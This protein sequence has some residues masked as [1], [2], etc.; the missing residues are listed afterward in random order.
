MD[1]NYIFMYRFIIILIFI[2]SFFCWVSATPKIS[3][4]EF[5][6]DLSGILTSKNNIENLSGTWRTY[7]AFSQKYLN[8]LEWFYQK[9]S[10]AFHILALR[11]M[12]DRSLSYNLRIQKYSLSCEITALRIILESFGII[13]SE[14]DI[15]QNIPSYL[16]VYETGGIWG[17]PDRQFVWYY[18]WS[19]SKKTGY[20]IYEKP[21]ADYAHIYW[22]T[23][24][25]INQWLYSGTTNSGI[26]LVHLLQ[27]LN[28]KKTHIILWWDW[29]TT[30]IYE[31][32]VLASWGKWLLEFFPLPWK[33]HCDRKSEDR[34]FYWKTSEGKEIQWLSGEHAYVLLGYVWTIKN[35]THIIVWDTYT[36]RHIYPYS[37]WM[38]KWSLMQYRSLI[39]SSE[40]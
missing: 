10:P 40:K 17:D 22:F 29:C 6:K 5:A 19:Q 20:G 2:F 38:R 35:P 15:F 31:D 12:V 8:D 16:F 39:I 1:S 28:D 24:N 14:I 7:V 9:Y 32:G 27:N 11:P 3:N 37:E 33:N 34:I 25:I 21:L 13:Q 26:H 36:W 4:R 18:T 23:T 30:P